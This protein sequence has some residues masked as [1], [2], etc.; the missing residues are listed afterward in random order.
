[1]VDD[2]GEF[3][4]VADDEAIGWTAQ[5]A[6]LR[7][8]L[9]DLWKQFEGRAEET[10]GTQESISHEIQ[11]GAGHDDQEADEGTAEQSPPTK[12]RRENRTQVGA[13]AIVTTQ[14]PNRA[15][16]KPAVQEEN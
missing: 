8:E 9:R 1:M 10:C 12:T 6:R 4:E 13:A 15:G 11:G 14:T 3:S 7:R 2:S 16:R 5:R